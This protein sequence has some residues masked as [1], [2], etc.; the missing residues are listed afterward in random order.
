MDFGAGHL[1]GHGPGDGP[2]ARAQVHHPRVR[3]ALDVVDDQLDH[4]LRFRAGNKDARAHRELEIA[5]MR[6]AGDVLQRNALGPFGHQFRIARRRR[7][8]PQ[9]HGPQPAEPHAEQMVRQQFGVD[10]GAGNPGIPEDRRG[11]ADG[12]RQG[13]P[14]PECHVCA[15]PAG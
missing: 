13:L 5:E 9:H 10:P 6:D 2:G 14:R 1:V 4:G 11:L 12:S 8:V 15:V 3:H 7:S